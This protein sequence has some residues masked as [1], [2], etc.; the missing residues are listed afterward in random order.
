MDFERVSEWIGR[1]EGEMVE[2][3][4]E[5]TRR[6]ALGPESGGQGEWAKASF[7][8]EYVRGAGLT[9]VAHYDCPDSRVPEGSRPNFS[10][11]VR[12]SKDAPCTWVLTH[13]DVVPP[14]EQNPDGTW[15]GWD[16]DPYEVRRV[17]DLLVGRGVGD[18]Q[19]AIVSS[20][21]AAR[22]LIECKTVPPHAVKLLFVSDEECGSERGLQHV[23]RA[24]RDMFGN[25]DVIYAPDGGN[26]ESTMI[27]VAEKS[28]LWL[29]FRVRGKQSHGSRPDLGINAFR[30]AATLVNRLDERLHRRFDA[31]N[32]LFE[33]PGSTFEP[34]LHKANV[35]NV[36]TI[37]GED[38]F[39][40]DCRVLPVYDLQ[41]V[42]H[43]IEAECRSLDGHLGT[44][45]ELLVRNRFP[46]A[47]GTSPASTA[48]R[49]LEPAIRNVYGVQARTMGIGGQTVAAFFRSEGLPAAVWMTTTETGHQV[50]ET[51]S[52]THMVGDA[53][54]FAQVFLSEF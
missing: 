39:C 16:G 26:A 32:R 40:F 12:G 51:C 49:L 29:E 37:P 25:D 46:A 1:H 2:L 10:A 20:V 3:Q 24:H 7:L 21:F 34:T 47:P 28:V 43:Y 19:Q 31:A 17:G 50:N 27:E 4:A 18:N 13:M 48:V 41:E 8:E 11:A 15:K 42:L 53:R 14:G 44:Q 54:V 5:L 36:N 9:D 45:T 52:V 33:P 23:L 6:P 38:V 30:A 35:P 22:A